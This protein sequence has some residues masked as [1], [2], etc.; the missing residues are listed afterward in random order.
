LSFDYFE[1]NDTAS[2]DINESLTIH[3]WV[4][5]D[6]LPNKRSKARI[7]SKAEIN[8][9][10]QT[11]NLSTADVT[12]FGIDQLDQLGI[13]VGSG[14]FNNDGIDDLIIGANQ[15]EQPGGNNQGETYIIYGPFNDT[16]VFNLSTAN[17]TFFGIDASDLSGIVVG[18]GDFNNDGIDDVIIGARDAEPSGKEAADEKQGETYIVYGPINDTGV[19]NL[20]TA[21]VTFFGIDASD[22]SG[23]GVGSGDLNND[24]IDD[25]I[26]GAPLAE[27][28]GGI[29]QGETYIIYGPI[30]DTGVFNLSIAN[31]TLFGIDESDF[32][33]RTVGSGDFNN[34]GIDDVI[35][36]AQSAEP[37]GGGI[38]DDQG[39]TYIVYGPINDTGVFNL[40]NAN[41]TFFGIDEDDQ[42]G[43]GVGS[44]DFNNDGIDDVIIG[45]FNAEQP[46]GS[47]EGE[48]Y[49]LYGPINE[50]G[51]FNLSNVTNVTF[52]GIDASDQAGF[53]VGSGDFDNDGVDDVIIGARGAEPAGG[54][55]QG[56]TYI[57]YGPL[58]LQENYN[59]M[60]DNNGSVIFS[61]MGNSSLKTNKTIEKDKFSS[62]TAVVDGANDLMSVYIDGVLEANR[63][64]HGNADNNNFS[65]FIGAFSTANASN[66]NGTIDELAIWNRSLSAD[67]ILDLSRLKDG[68]YY[69]KV[70]ASDESNTA[71]NKTFE[72]L[73]DTTGPIVNASLN[74]SLTN[75]FQDDVINITAN[76]TDTLGL[77]IGQI[78]V[79]DTGIKR[80]FNFSL[81]G[82]AD[83]FSQNFTVS[84]GGGCVVN[85]TARANDTFNNFKT[86][87][88]IFTVPILP[89][90]LL[91]SPANA[92][93]I[94]T[95][96]NL[97]NTTATDLDN[98]NLDIYIWGSNSSEITE[99]GNHSLLYVTKDV[100]GSDAGINVTYNWTAPVVQPD[101]DTVL[102]LHFD[103]RSE[104]GENDSQV[105]D[106]S[107]YENNATCS[108]ADNKCP[109]FN[110][111]LG[112]FAGAVQL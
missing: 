85:V 43:L 34:D 47:S 33:G 17:V 10:N 77:S 84:C 80:Y 41:V 38:S 64:V 106:F 40:S 107:G 66:L 39:E 71:E 51:V 95:N 81:S 89:T 5:L 36:G 79:N 88:T 25:V 19:F 75:I 7:L 103:S 62:I 58:Q 67:E 8:G 4:K 76:V 112:K 110:L 69:W 37:A 46:G 54:N 94:A 102:L 73:I 99:I 15:A 29:D 72:F 56:E 12:F 2:L 74:E 13:G 101:K 108:L 1:I 24:G 96:Y 28:P 57:I 87:D 63:S 49:I 14:D 50:S 82:T 44:G 18:S 35:I 20:S 52:L 100:S 32:S 92:S 70:N 31:V 16:G 93:G 104:F 97:L 21:N 98:D 53:A 23:G 65:L 26:I 55:A 68:T 86:N 60:V 30:N 105:F 83:E 90:I 48:T 109:A 61:F 42:I 45:A 22:F 59:L 9:S 111:T 11:T 91:N 6:S 3:A 78:I 27:Q